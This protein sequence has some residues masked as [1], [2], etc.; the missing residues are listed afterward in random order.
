M[1]P[2]VLM[3]ES[4][5]ALADLEKIEVIV[6]KGASPGACR[7]LGVSRS[8]GGLLLFLDDDVVI[9]FRVL[10]RVCKHFDDARVGAVGGPNL[11]L[12]PASF[13][14]RCSGYV[15]SSPIGSSVMS[16]RYKV[17]LGPLTVDE[18]MLTG[19]NLMVRRK[20]FLEAGGFPEDIFPAEENILL[21]K[22]SKL[23][24]SLV[25]DPG[26]V[27]FHKRRGFLGHFIQVFRYGRGR[28]L[29][30]KRFPDSFRLVFSLPSAG[31]LVYSSLGLLSVFGF[32]PFFLLLALGVSYFCLV[33]FESVRVG[34]RNRDF[35]AIPAMTVFFPMHHLSY[36]LGFL[37]GLIKG[38]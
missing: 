2:G 17:M 34:R 11:T 26:F 19:C 38:K 28:A 24:Y 32:V 12:N 3:L 33:C 22:I 23:G 4:G 29:M 18:R 15:L 5:D 37:L 35:A 8:S 7:N 25:Y 10:E 27:V 20:A 14:E 30:V 6:V 31:L 16:W 1:R 36:A 21:H 9:D 13:W